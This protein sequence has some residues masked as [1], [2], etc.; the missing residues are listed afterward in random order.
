MNY[1]YISPV[2]EVIY[3]PDNN[4]DTIITSNTDPVKTTNG[5]QNDQMGVIGKDYFS[6]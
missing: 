3:F 4:I 5:S 1:D 2:I 6:P